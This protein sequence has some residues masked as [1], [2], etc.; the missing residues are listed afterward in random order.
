MHV[1]PNSCY[2]NTNASSR[3]IRSLIW[4]S[5]V[6]V[7]NIGQSL[8]VLFIFYFGETIWWVGVLK[9]L[10]G[11]DLGVLWIHRHTYVVVSF[12]CIGVR[13]VQ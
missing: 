1:D 3:P 9:P 7:G 13:R 8:V 5:R 2:Y 6:L 10:N 4:S 11:H 12:Q